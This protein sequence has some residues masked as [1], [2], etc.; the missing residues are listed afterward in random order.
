MP[1][2]TRRDRWEEWMER[3]LQLLRGQI[4]CRRGAHAGARFGLGR[5]VRILYPACFWAG[6]DVS[7]ENY[8]YLHCL[9]VR[10]V[11]FGNHT[12]VGTNLWLAC[13]LKPGNEGCFEIGDHSYIGPNAVIGAGGPVSIGS[14]V[15]FGPNVTLTAENHVFAD[16]SR[17]IDEQGVSHQGIVIEDDCWIGGRASILDGVRV[18]RGSVIGAGA[19]VTRDIPP[20]SVAAGVPAHVIRSRRSS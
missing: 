2:I 16:L 6:D 12:S 7:I 5:A 17:R 19:V 13:G 20:Y 9:S 1:E 18:G 4:A 14:H 11:R 8:G 3:K 15:Q 10:G